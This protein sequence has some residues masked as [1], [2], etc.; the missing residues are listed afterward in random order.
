MVISFKTGRGGGISVFCGGEY[1]TRVDNDFA[2]SCG[3]KD[4]DDID[5]AELDCFI[6]AACSRSAFLG[7]MRLL[8]LRDHGKKELINKLCEKGH[9]REYAVMAVDRAEEL[10]YIDDEAFAASLAEKLFSQKGY[11]PKKIQYELT[12]K[13]IS[14]EIAEITVQTLDFDAEMRIIEILQTKFS[15]VADDEKSRRKAVNALLRMGYSYSD[16]SSAMRKTEE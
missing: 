12:L 4:N 13:G 10:G 5:G 9:M 6:E 3:V 11:S 2:L 7:A 16:I 1:L 14:R 8:S 15:G